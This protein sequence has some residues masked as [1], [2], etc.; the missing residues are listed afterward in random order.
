MAERW[1]LVVV[2]L[3]MRRIGRVQFLRMEED[4]NKLGN[5]LERQMED[6]E[7]SMAMKKF[8][9]REK[10]WPQASIRTLNPCHNSK[11][12]QAIIVQLSAPNVSSTAIE[13][14]T[15]PRT[16]SRSRTWFLQLLM[17]QTLSM[18]LSTPQRTTIQL[19]LLFQ[20]GELEKIE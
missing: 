20:K 4:K 12:S 5:S 14:P 16:A 2:Q 1:W 10:Q 19:W 6:M 8:N 18:L 15:A 13:L 11:C 17:F 3:G 7:L 9:M